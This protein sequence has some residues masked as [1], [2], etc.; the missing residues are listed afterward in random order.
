MGLIVWRHTP[1]YWDYYQ[2]EG[3]FVIS[4]IGDE[5]WEGVA[6]TVG[7][8]RD[9]EA[10]ARLISAAPDLLVALIEIEQYADEFLGIHD[11]G[12]EFVAWLQHARDAITKATAGPPS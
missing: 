1:G 10:N 6:A 3:G 4:A 5:G 9:R 7:R 12:P 11:A 2:E 8:H